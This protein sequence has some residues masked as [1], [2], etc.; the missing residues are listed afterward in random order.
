MFF[1]G[2]A[3]ALSSPL[4]EIQ[5]RRSSDPNLAGRASVHDFQWRRDVFLLFI[6]FAL[7]FGAVVLPGVSSHNAE[8]VFGSA[9]LLIPSSSLGILSLYFLWEFGNS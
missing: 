9:M 1:R 2:I 8:F 7:L 4:L 6:L 3:E 5:S